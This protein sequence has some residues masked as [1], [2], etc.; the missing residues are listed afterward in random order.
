MLLVKLLCAKLLVLVHLCFVG[1][2]NW[3]LITWCLP[4]PSSYR[5]H[6]KKY[7]NTSTFPIVS[8][9]FKTLQVDS[10]F[11][12]DYTSRLVIVE[13]EREREMCLEDTKSKIGL[14][15]GGDF[16]PT[17][18]FDL[19]WLRPGVFP[20]S[21]RTEKPEMR[22]RIEPSPPL[23]C[24]RQI[25]LKR[26]KAPFQRSITSGY[27]TLHSLQVRFISRQKNG[28]TKQEKGRNMRSV[29]IQML[30]Q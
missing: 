29:I 13:R 12:S 2:W 4:W 1:W 15:G 26:E 23:L 28:K 7:D 25:G 27:S 22:C 18:S 8:N 30:L 5:T 17:H 19:T 24:L 21:P 6:A 10:I 11:N 9:F 3:S 16:W 14:H 20:I